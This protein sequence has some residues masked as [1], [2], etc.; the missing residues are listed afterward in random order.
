MSDEAFKQA[1]WAL[2][3]N[4]KWCGGATGPAKAEVRRRCRRM[5]LV[6]FLEL[7]TDAAGGRINCWG[8][9]PAEEAKRFAANADHFVTGYS[10]DHA[11]HKLGNGDARKGWEM[12]WR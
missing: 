1:A 4:N 6:F 3:S 2:G 11:A 12:Y 7:S 10:L 5:G 8:L 9:V